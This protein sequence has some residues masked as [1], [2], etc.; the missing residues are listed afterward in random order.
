LR[1]DFLEI[2]PPNLEDSETVALMTAWMKTHAVKDSGFI[3]GWEIQSQL[4]RVVLISMMAF[5]SVWL[6]ALL[7]LGWSLVA[8]HFYDYYIRRGRPD[9]LQDHKVEKGPLARGLTVYTLVWAIKLVFAGPVHIVLAKGTRFTLA[10]VAGQ[11]YYRLVRALTLLFGSFVGGVTV[12]HHLLRTS[13]LSRAQVY[14]G[15]L[16]G[17]FSNLGYQVLYSAFLI[18]L[19]GFALAWTRGIPLVGV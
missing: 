4:S 2:A 12:C 9:L 5:V 3:V 16:A 17:R 13:G 6:G 8:A 10:T 7:I 11:P 14:W 19:I 18:Q 1:L 15:T